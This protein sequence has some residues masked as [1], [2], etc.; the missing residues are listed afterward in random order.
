M[1]YYFTPI[2]MAKIKM[3]T[4]AE[5]DAAKLEP[6]LIA[7]GSVNRCRHHDKN[8]KVSKNVKHSDHTTQQFTSMYISKTTENM[9]KQMSVH[10]CSQQCY[11]N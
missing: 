10:E 4:N 6:S 1:I 2:R 9:S 3:I 7:A 11:S 5:E 8:L